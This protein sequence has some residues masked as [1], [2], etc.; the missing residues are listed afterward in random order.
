MMPTSNSE[1]LE[2]QRKTT[3]LR[4]QHRV[5]IALAKLSP[6][7][8][9]VETQQEVRA[10]Y[11]TDDAL[12]SAALGPSHETAKK[13]MKIAEPLISQAF[14]DKQDVW[15]LVEGKANHPST[16]YS[17]KAALQYVL[18]DRIGAI[19]LGID[20]RIRACGRGGATSRDGGGI[21]Q[22]L[23]ELV[24]LANA[25]DSTPV[26]LPPKLFG[27]S[28]RSK[29]S[30][31]MSIRRKPENWREQIACTLNGPVKLAYLIQ[32]LTGC[33]N[34][35]L[36]N[37]VIVVKHPN[38][39]LD[40]TISGAKLGKNAGQK[41]RGFCVNVAGN[42]LAEILG[43]LLPVGLPF[44]SRNFVSNKENYRKAVARASQRVFPPKKGGCALSAYS[45]RHQFKKDAAKSASRE[46]LA[47]AMGHSTT[48]SAI[49]YGRGGKAGSGAVTPVDI[50][51][52]R[53]VKL[54]QSIGTSA[55]MNK[56]ATAGIAATKLR[57]RKPGP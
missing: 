40:F 55:S 57:A 23:S 38:G 53:P 24:G 54:R 9:T 11:K 7:G 19:K 20:E 31:S 30:K 35:E 39:L 41:T 43:K 36:L 32:A 46:A 45:L 12:L 28:K 49:H 56:S 50:K 8:A 51:A 29:N 3:E 5:R 52:T 37:G 22:A 42:G 48:R 47:Q 10:R 6:R 14:Q 21:N 13:Y 33:R 4:R 44:D 17:L 34:Q 16:W 1:F 25:L 26:C 15:Q 18:I 2:L 27:V